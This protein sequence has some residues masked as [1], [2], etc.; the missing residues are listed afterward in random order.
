MRSKACHIRRR[1][2][3]GVETK[4]V[5]ALMGPGMID[6][7]N[8]VL[9]RLIGDHRSW[10]REAL[11]QGATGHRICGQARP[12]WAHRNRW[13]IVCGGRFPCGM[14]RQQD[15]AIGPTSRFGGPMAH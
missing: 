2:R 3:I 14:D 11:G 6:L 5:I 1:H 8:L 13:K 4:I 15:R 9:V 10:D 7:K 12:E